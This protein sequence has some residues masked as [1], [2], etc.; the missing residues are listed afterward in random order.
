MK[1]I[2][3]A[4][5]LLIGVASCNSPAPPANIDSKP[6]TVTVTW[7]PSSFEDTARAYRQ[8]T[9]QPAPAGL[10]GLTTRQGDH[11]Y[12]YAPLPARVDDKPTLIV[13]HEFLHAC[14]GQYHELSI[15]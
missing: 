14:K 5:A 9:G 1:R 4:L 3:L 11:F 2:L 7:Y 10:T 13:G 12:L 6:C 8:A 15:P